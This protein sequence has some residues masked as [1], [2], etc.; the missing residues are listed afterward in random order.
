MSAATAKL[1]NS[2]LIVLVLGPPPLLQLTADET[3][4]RSFTQAFQGATA[5]HELTIRLRAKPH[6][7][8]T[9]AAVE[10]VPTQLVTLNVLHDALDYGVIAQ[11]MVIMHL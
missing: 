2:G 10:Q 9:G 11:W 5:L 7:G 3:A 6:A 4:D 1:P 8:S